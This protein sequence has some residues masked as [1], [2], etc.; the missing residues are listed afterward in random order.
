MTGAEYLTAAVLQRLWEALDAAFRSELAESGASVQVF[1]SRRSPAWNLVG[2]VHFNLAEN[3]KDDEAPF[4]FLATYTTRLSAH[5]KAQHVPLGQALREYAGAANKARL[6]SLLLPVQ[7]AAEQC[8]WLKAMVDAGE[9][10]HPLRWTPAEAFQLLTDVPLLEAA[11]VVVR[12]PGTWRANR[13]PRPQ[14]SATVGGKP[15]SGLGADALLDFQMEVTLDGE[16]LTAAEIRALLASSNGLHLVRGRWVEVDREK[17]A[18]MLDEF[19]AVE[20]AAA[21]DGLSFAEAMRLVA[22]A[23]VSGGRTPGRRSRLVARRRRA[24]AG[25]HARRPAASRGAGAGR[26]R[27]RAQ[28][29]AAAVPA[30][31][32][33]LAPPPLDARPRRLPGRR[34]GTGQDDAGAGAV[35]G[36]TAGAG[37]RAADQPARRARVAAREL[38]VGDRALRAGVCGR[39]SRIRRRCRPPIGRRSI[40]SGSRTSIS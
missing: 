19:R 22:G 30:G 10:Y 14:V 37:R 25:D 4:A 21:R 39:S 12:V 5:A 2:R 3:R 11:G 38:G 13:P 35:A 9:I 34:H 33:A 36:A 8:A 20:Q 32:R 15:P 1:L 31:R 18:T 6:L 7:R 29:D 26:A 40:R 16:R 23:D 24:M 28:D 17:L 27:R